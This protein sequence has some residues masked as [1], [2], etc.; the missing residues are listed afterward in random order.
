MLPFF[1]S[2]QGIQEV[3]NRYVSVFGIVG[4]GQELEM[5]KERRPSTYRKVV[6][7]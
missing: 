5:G 3:L 4:P 6:L 2:F 1:F 7:A